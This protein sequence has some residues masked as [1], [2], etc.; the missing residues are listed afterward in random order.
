MHMLKKHI[1]PTKK[2]KVEIIKE[3]ENKYYKNLR[4]IMQTIGNSNLE[5]LSTGIKEQYF[6]EEKEENDIFKDFLKNI[7]KKGLEAYQDLNLKCLKKTVALF[8]EESDISTKRELFNLIYKRYKKT[9]EI[10]YFSKNPNQSN[11][12]AAIEAHKEM[13]EC[14]TFLSEDQKELLNFILQNTKMSSDPNKTY[15]ENKDKIPLESFKKLNLLDQKKYLASLYQYRNDKKTLLDYTEII[16]TQK[17]DTEYKHNLAIQF[18]RCFVPPLS[19]TNPLAFLTNELL[20]HQ[21]DPSLQRSPNAPSL[22]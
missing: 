3:I 18:A 14:N 1:S 2:L 21:E 4:S 10:C 20:K 13:L 15:F 8:K 5:I 6:L 7:T 22:H 9:I 16:L 17:F 19:F 12:L 11:F